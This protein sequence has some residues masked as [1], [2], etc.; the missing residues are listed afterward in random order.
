MANAPLYGRRWAQS[1]EPPTDGVPL[2]VVQFNVLADGLSGRDKKLGSFDAAPPASLRWAARRGRLLEEIFRHGPDPDVICLEEVDHFGDWFQPQLA[3]RGYRGFFLKKPKSPCLKT[4]PG[5]GLE[6]GCAPF[7]REAMVS[8]ARVE[9]MNYEASNQVALLATVYVTGKSTPFIIACTHFTA[10]KTAEGEAKRK[11]QVLE[12]LA[13]LE[14]TGLPCV[15]CLDMNAAPNDASSYAAEA[16]SATIGNLR[17]AYKTALGAEPAWTTWKRRGASEARH[18]IDYIL[19]SSEVGVARVLLAPD[20][21][22]IVEA[23]LPGWNYPSDHIALLAEL[24]VPTS[25]L[26]SH[27]LEPEAGKWRGALSIVAILGCMVLGPCLPVAALAALW[28]GYATLAASLATFVAIS[29]TTG[30]HSPRL[31]RVPQGGGLVWRWRLAARVSRGAAMHGRPGLDALVHAP[32]WDKH[33]LR[34]FLERRRALQD[35]R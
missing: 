2:R 5:S 18:C 11:V 14:A 23:R 10:S 1:A 6:D 28:C 22:A 34:L 3:Q 35:R 27:R 21:A 25:P 32:A 7:V 17:S 33:R 30:A 31:R 26:V 4:A 8:V 9:N 19:C 15:V 13:R 12:L 20:D 16:Y 29:L 24:S